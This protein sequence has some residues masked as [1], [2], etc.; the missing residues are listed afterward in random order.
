MPR[1]FLSALAGL[2]LLS[3][4]ASGDSGADSA[5]AGD[6]AAATGIGARLAKYTPV[7]LTTDLSALSAQERQMLPLLIDAANEMDAIFWQQAYG[8]REQLMSRIEDP[9]ARRFA[10]I[11]YGPW[12]RLAGNEPFVP[13][14][15]PKP[16]GANLYPADITKEE[17]E[18]AVAGG[19][20]R[21]DSLRSLYT[22]VR[23]D[24]SGALTAVPYHVAFASQVERAAAKLREAS[25]LAT[26]P[27]LKRYLDLRARALQTDEFQPSDLAWMD[28]KNNTIDVV[29][30]P[31][32]TYEDQLFG[33][34]AANE[35]YVLVKD[36]EWSKRLARYAAMLP[37]LQRGLPV[38]AEFKRETPG[39]DSDLGAYDAVYYAG[40][41]NAGSKTI[42]IN[43]PNDEQVQLR[44]GTRRLQ[45]KNAMRAKFDAILVPIANEL[46]VPEQRQ[47]VTFDAFFANTMFHE[48]AHG[49]G[50]KNTIN[51]RGTVREALKERASALEEGKADV[52]G[53]YMVTRLHEQG[54][55]G[56]ADLRD[57]YVTFLASIFRSARFGAASAHGR[58]NMARFNFFEERGAFARDSSGMYRV[59]FDKMRDAMNALSEHILR[60]QG[61]GDYA[62]A[63]T[64]MEQQGTIGPE[65]QRSLDRLATAGIPVDIVF[66]QGMSVLRASTP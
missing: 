27:G 32:E 21:A 41:A 29:I 31:I 58:A 3:G 64:F 53:L 43:L 30:G 40:D 6:T 65:L 14:V 35:T 55:L 66:E 51:D 61:E 36:Q 8:S 1:S 10:E 4:C 37:A 25:A 48:V 5:A 12:D 22:L 9:D 15:G 33:Y 11:N 60:L 45:L 23:R 50:V 26:D 7:R 57:N 54:E 52:L 20:A 56:D 62:G 17:F 13:G 46:I 63:T 19:G 39:T 42:A 28:M 2:A 24:S 16:P 18:Q 59:D 49:L 34:K 38:P 44:K 47:H